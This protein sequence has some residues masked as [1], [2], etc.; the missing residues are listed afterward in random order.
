MGDLFA[1]EAL[2]T[3]ETLAGR[4]RPVRVLR[5]ERVD[6]ASMGALMMHFMLETIL[7]AGLLGVDAFDQP[8]VEEGKRLARE[9]LAAMA[10]R[11]G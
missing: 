1:A 8:A 6:E 4:N 2:A 9:Y 10:G 11:V 5:L 3:I 7:A